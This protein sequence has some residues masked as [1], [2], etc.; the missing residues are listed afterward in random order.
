MID[1]PLYVPWYYTWLKCWAVAVFIGNL[2]VVALGTA[3]L[4]R[5]PLLELPPDAPPLAQSLL[6]MFEL[7]RIAVG[8]GIIAG[9]E[10]RCD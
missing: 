3:L 6:Q 7:V 2:G 1:R 9:A 8:L 4:L 10:F 5:G